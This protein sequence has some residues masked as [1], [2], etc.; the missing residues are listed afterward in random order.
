MFGFGADGLNLGPLVVNWGNLSLMLGV[1]TWFWLARFA[2]GQAV[3][4]V[5]LA[6]ARL[7]ATLPGWTVS[8][9]LLDNLWD[10]LDV[11]RG[12]W[13]WGPG[14]LAGLLYTLAL[15][16]R[17][18][19]RG[20]QPPLAAAFRAAVPALLAGGLPLLLRPSSDVIQ[21]PAATFQPL[22]ATSAQALPASAVV[23]LWASWCGPCRSEMPLLLS[24]GQHD[25]HLILLNVGEDRATVE[26]F[27]DGLSG[28]AGGGAK[29]WLGGEAVT[30]P[31]R[32]TGFP[33]TLVLNSSGQIVARHLGPLT[34][35][36][37]LKLQYL[38]Q[39]DMP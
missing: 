30:G 15:S 33:T 12:A 22:S 26:R 25:P 35:A 16:W 28:T 36:D 10:V 21:L 14:L 29:V 8:R 24:E 38:A 4:L 20:Q 5:T 19:R 39:K 34:R 11:R 6:T 1:L 2:S 37:L 18:T 3:A 31:L 23:N 17:A 32:V 27:L 9:P 7:W 13:A